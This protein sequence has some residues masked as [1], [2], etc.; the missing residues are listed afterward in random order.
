MI[1]ELS[2]EF[3]FEAAHTLARDYDAESSRRVHGHTYHAEVIVRGE[4]D[5]QTGMI[6]DLVLLRAHIDRVRE[7]LDHHLL[8]EITELGKPTLENLSTFIARQL[9]ALEAR[10]TAVRVWRAASG[11]SC[12][13]RFSENGQ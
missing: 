1:L 12:T 7:I 9:R 5:A 3:Y 11:D 13:C 6:V 8:D 10:V 4:P 2:Q